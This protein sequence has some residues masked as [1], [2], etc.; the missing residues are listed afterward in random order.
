MRQ[1]NRILHLNPLVLRFLGAVAVFAGCSKDSG[2]NCNNTPTA[3]A[4]LP[5][6]IARASIT[7]FN[8]PKVVGD[9]TM[10]FATATST[11]GSALAEPTYN[12]NSIAAAAKPAIIMHVPAAGT[13]IYGARPVQAGAILQNALEETFT[14]P[15][16]NA[17]ST[18]DKTTIALGQSVQVTVPG[19]FGRDSVVVFEG[20]VRRA[21]ML[22]GGG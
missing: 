12:G 6:P 17:T 21:S 18:I 20:G 22:E 2:I 9:T 7:I 1:P 3:P 11:R 19:Q 13:A 5:P 8:G 4:C 14:V 15:L 10:G 16:I